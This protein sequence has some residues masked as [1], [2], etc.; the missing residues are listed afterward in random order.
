MPCQWVF[1][2]HLQQFK[3]NRQKLETVSVQLMSKTIKFKSFLIIA[4][5]GT[6]LCSIKAYFKMTLI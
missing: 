3:E 4:G 6:L 1:V 2:N 5:C